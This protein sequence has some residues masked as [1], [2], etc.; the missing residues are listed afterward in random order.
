M[1]ERPTCRRFSRDSP[2]GEPGADWLYRMSCV[3]CAS[4]GLTG[5]MAD[6]G[7]MICSG[8]GSSC[9]SGG[10]HSTTASAIEP[11]DWHPS[12]MGLL[13]RDRLSGVIAPLSPRWLG[14]AG[15]DLCTAR[16]GGG[17]QRTTCTATTKRILTS[18]R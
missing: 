13:S 18:L 15:A 14:D 1:R 12:G 9:C 2:E 6:T 11:F 5:G 17:S 8:G 3:M 16:T 7:W 10:W 4:F